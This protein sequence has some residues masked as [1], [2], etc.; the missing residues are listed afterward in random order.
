M[1]LMTLGKM[2]SLGVR[3]LS[4]RAGCWSLQT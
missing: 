3:S 2:R 4:R 1:R